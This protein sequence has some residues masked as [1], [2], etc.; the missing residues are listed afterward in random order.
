MTMLQKITAHLAYTFTNSFIKSQN[1]DNFW[2][3]F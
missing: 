2:Q 1:T 3:K